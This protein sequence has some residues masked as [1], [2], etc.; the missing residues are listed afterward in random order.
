M[1]F[2]LSAMFCV[3]I[4]SAAELVDTI[5]LVRPS[6]VAVGTFKP[7]ANPQ[8]TFRVTGFAVGDGSLVVTNAHVLPNSVDLDAYESVAIAIPG[9]TLPVHQGERR[10][11]SQPRPNMIWHSSNLRGRR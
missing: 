5:K 7:T 9:T 6:I 3:H 8:F 11:L 1:L 10:R 2:F 4:S